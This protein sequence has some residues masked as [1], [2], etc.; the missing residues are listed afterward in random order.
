[1]SNNLDALRKLTDELD[2][3]EHELAKHDK[4]LLAIVEIQNILLANG[5]TV[6]PAALQKLGETTQVSKA[7]VFT[8]LMYEGR[9][10]A[11]R[12]GMW[13]APENK[14]PV[15]EHFAYDEAGLLYDEL[16]NNRIVHSIPAPG[17]EPWSVILQKFELNSSLLIPLFVKQEFMDSWALVIMKVLRNGTITN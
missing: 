7:F 3:K 9:I 8:N 5:G 1:M 17:S 13:L 15:V 2:E 16:S 14:T 10:Y 12:Q 4:Y 11:S 6:F